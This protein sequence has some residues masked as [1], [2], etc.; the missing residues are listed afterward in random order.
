MSS[1]TV[2]AEQHLA[3]AEVLLDRRIGILDGILE[4]FDD[5][6]TIRMARIA[7]A[8]EQRLNAMLRRTQ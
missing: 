8:R 7:G 3:D 5:A 1:H 6:T 2:P 4:I